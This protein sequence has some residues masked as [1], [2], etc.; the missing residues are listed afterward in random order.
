MK[1]AILTSGGDAPGMNAAIRSVTRC[2]ITQGMQVY[3]IQRGFQGLLDGA[4]H[5]MSFNDVSDKLQRGGT[6]LQ[7][8]RCHEFRTLEGQK[9][10]FDVLKTFGIDAIVII[11]GD[12]SLAGGLALSKLGM[13]V[14]GI[15]GTIDNDLGYTDYTIGFDTA[16]NT[17]LDAISKI[18]DTSSSH[19]RT[20]IIE[21]MGRNCGDLALYA[22]IAGGAESVIIP[23]I[24]YDINQICQRI[25]LGRNRGKVHNIILKAEGVDISAEDL[26]KLIEDKT[27]VESRAVILA[28]L[29]RGGSPTA[30]DR[31]LATKCGQKAVELIAAGSTSRAIGCYGTEIIHMDLENA[32]KMK[33]EFD[34]DLYDLSVVLS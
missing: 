13:P 34:K 10:G 15:P 14:M 3:G 27:G 25:I 30:R 19:E 21:V 31:L 26:A 7:T 1:I 4:F 9:R 28:Y 24:G 18:R 23:E 22:G 17:V 6:M 33:R 2:A 11:G 12:G 29:Q 16:V 32:L 20:T 5:E 8:A